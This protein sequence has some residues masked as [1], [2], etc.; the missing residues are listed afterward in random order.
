MGN[1]SSRTAYLKKNGIGIDK[2]GIELYYKKF[3]PQINLS[4]NIFN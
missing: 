1:S 2:F 4:V 3:N